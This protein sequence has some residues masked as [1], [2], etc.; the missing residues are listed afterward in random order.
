[1]RGR[2]KADVSLA[3]FEMHA[4]SFHSG[5]YGVFMQTMEFHRAAGRER[6]FRDRGNPLG[7]GFGEK[8][9]L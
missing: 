8:N 3:F 5:A 4:R 1:M 7:K 6:N 2:R 9:Y